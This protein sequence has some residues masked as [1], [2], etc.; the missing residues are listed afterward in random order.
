MQV[1][2]SSLFNEGD[3]VIPKCSMLKDVLCEVL[4]L[5]WSDALRGFQYRLSTS[6]G[7]VMWYDEKDLVSATEARI[8]DI[9]RLYA[10][11]GN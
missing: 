10:E 3:L 2:V 1:I 11:Y 7:F 6:H 4:E 5:Q 8:K 9:E